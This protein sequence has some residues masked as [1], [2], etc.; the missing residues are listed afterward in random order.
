MTTISDI[1]AALFTA[2]HADLGTYDLSGADAVK[3]GT[4]SRPPGEAGAPFACILP[5]RQTT[6]EPRARDTHYLETYEVEIR[7]W[8]P[9]TATGTDNRTDASLAV[10]AEVKKALDA[11]RHGNT[12]ITKCVSFFCR[13][14]DPHPSAALAPEGWALVALTYELSHNRRQGT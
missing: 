12:A 14:A 6:S 5:P 3:K 7:V 13:Q 9:Y 11:A 1:V 4:Y 8:A 2:L 10:A